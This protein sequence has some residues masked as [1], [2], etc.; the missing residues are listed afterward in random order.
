MSETEPLRLGGA[1]G[2][3]TLLALI[4]GARPLIAGYHSIEDQLQP[5][6][7]DL[8]VAEIGEFVNGGAIGRTNASRSLPDVR[9]SAV[10]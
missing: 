3:E 8:S 7:F 4:Q 10:R 5:N 1:L 2:R 6:G 9:A